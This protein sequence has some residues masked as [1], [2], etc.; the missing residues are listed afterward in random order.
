MGI[1]G[2]LEL[3]RGVLVTA[4]GVVPAEWHGCPEIVVEGV[5]VVDALHRAW[6]DRRAVVVRLRVDP[7]DFRAPGSSD[8]EPWTLG[9]AFE[10][11]GDRLHFLLWANNADGRSLGEGPI[12]WWARKAVRLGAVPVDAEGAGDV[13]LD[14]GEAVWIDGGPRQPLDLPTVHAESVDLRRLT[15]AAHPSPATPEIPLAPD[16]LGAVNHLTGPARIIAPAGSGKTRVLAERMRHLLGDRGYEVES[17]LAVA[18]NK[19]A[20]EE[21][22]TRCAAFRPRV[23]TLNAL[24]WELLGRPTVL[25]EREVR[26]I[27]ERLVP[28]PQR[29]ANVDPYVPYLEALTATRLGFVD[30]ATVE[31]D[32]DDVPGFAYAFALFRDELR[33]RNAVDFDEQIYGA[34]ERLLRDGEFRRRQQQRHRHLLV[35]EFQDLT[36]CH[37]L[38]LRLLAAPEFDVFGVGDDD[39]VIYGHAGADPAFLIGFDA[40]FPGA[41]SH[42]LEVNYRCPVAVVDAARTLLS[43]NRRR[44]PKEIRPGP[45]AATDPAGL[46]ICLHQPENGAS[47]AVAQ[48]KT[49]LASGAQ[50][51]DIAVL[52]R[53]TSLLLAPQVAL[54]TAA[55]PIDTVLDEYVLGRTGVR[56]ALAYLRIATAADGFAATDVIEIL[57]RPSRGLPI[58]IEK[59]IRGTKL[60]VRDV[61][62]IA[63]RVDDAKVSA[64]VISLAD[65]LQTVVDA[66]ARSNTRRLLRTIKDQVGLGQAM[67]L[68][69][70]SAASSHLDDLEALE[71]VADLHPDPAGFEPWLRGIL[72]N[73]GAPG[74]VTVSTVHRVK[75]REWPYVAIFGVSDGIV[76]HRL[77]ADHEEERRV[78]HVAITRASRQAVVFGDIERVSPF[79]GELDG[80]A[81]RRPEP[82]RSAGRERTL[83]KQR[84]QDPS[85]GMAAAR[86]ALLGDPGMLDALRAWRRTRAKTDGVP[87]YVVL[88]DRHLS[89]IAVAHPETMAALAR[90]EGMG[91]RRLELYGED[92]LAAVAAT[93][94]SAG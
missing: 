56:A 27:I 78:L 85:G 43:Y 84:S 64:K 10:F 65:D 25:E 17:M 39:Q 46:T 68:L 29:R 61:R 71:Q 60:H 67:S 79:I 80:S 24:A 93:A 36:P 13:R 58:W 77:S 14:S 57:R 76:P 38:L 28:K 94:P 63:D 12:W 70:A 9:P 52:S 59:W 87:P 35:D 15:V 54:A 34:V 4:E 1:R 22:S 7:T 47:E 48:V 2:P 6:L 33:R 19:K 75:G 8:A 69:D 82:I 11:P 74:G 83:A 72:A 40:L 26:S 37:V 21:L 3:G 81:A 73:R 66:G 23:S 20:Q 88:H 42:P 89:A 49:W 90:I 55:V 31:Q 53:V 91:P 5:G 44:V 62:A 41:A 92:I 16:Q 51:S 45:Q 32:R 18:Y 86:G 30:P 50:P